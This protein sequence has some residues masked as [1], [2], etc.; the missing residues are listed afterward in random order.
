MHILL[1]GSTG[2]L[3]SHLKARLEEE[4]HTLSFLRHGEGPRNFSK[5]FDAIIN[6]AGEL[7][8]VS[9]M[10]GTNLG[11][12][13]DLLHMA[14]RNGVAKFIQI[15][16]SAETGPVEGLRSETTFC[17]PSNLYE[18]TKLAATNLCVGYAREHKMDVSVAR[19]FTLYGSNDKPRKLL[20]TLWR[21][22]CEH[23]PINIFEGG[24]DWT[25]V[26]DFVEGIVLMLNAESAKTSGQIFNF[27]T[28]KSTSNIEVVRLFEKAVGGQL[29]VTIHS[30]LYRD[31]DV[32]DWRADKTKALNQLG[33]V[34]KTTLEEGIK[35][36]VMTEWFKHEKEPGL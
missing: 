15:G 2:F 19:P 3:G 23:Q 35:E 18:A 1:T 5:K 17:D 4:G 14:K 10:V 13:E 7:D 33:W 36:I 26:N 34:W 12:V 11:L 31:Y 21:A 29:N 24:H 9:D 32:L 16:S 20:P 8:E 30:E 28:G 6:C 27:G 22:F 25:H